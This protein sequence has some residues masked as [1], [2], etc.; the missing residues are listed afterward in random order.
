MAVFIA[1]ASCIEENNNFELMDTDFET[2]TR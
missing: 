1:T 2:A